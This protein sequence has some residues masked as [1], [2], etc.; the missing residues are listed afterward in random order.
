MTVCAY[1]SICLLGYFKYHGK[2]QRGDRGSGPPPPEKSKVAIC[3][4][5]YT[6]IDPPRKAI[7]PLSPLAMLFE[8]GLYDPL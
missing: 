4:L 8:G 1:K 2:I 7:G 6:G 5:R 3:L